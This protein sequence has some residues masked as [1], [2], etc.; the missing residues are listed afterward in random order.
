MKTCRFYNIEWDQSEWGD[1]D[2][3]ITGC[4]FPDLPSEITA[5]NFSDDFDPVKDGF[6]WLFEDIGFHPTKFKFKEEPY[7]EAMSKIILSDD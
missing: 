6:E 3:E 7:N 2:R 4:D 1:E 5:H